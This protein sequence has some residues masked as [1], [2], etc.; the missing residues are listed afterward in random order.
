MLLMVSDYFA[1]EK[2]RSIATIVSVCRSVWAT[3]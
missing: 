1:P 3:I 2:V